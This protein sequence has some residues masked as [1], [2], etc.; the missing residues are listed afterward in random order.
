MS[1]SPRPDEHPLVRELHLMAKRSFQD[2]QLKDRYDALRRVVMAALHK[3]QP[4]LVA[5]LVREEI[6]RLEDLVMTE[7]RQWRE[8]AE[9]I[10][11]QRHC[12]ALRAASTVRL[13]LQSTATRLAGDE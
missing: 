1:Y 13:F 7:A 8:A 4:G 10:D 9:A 12:Q 11:H 3:K 2:P 5:R 6:A